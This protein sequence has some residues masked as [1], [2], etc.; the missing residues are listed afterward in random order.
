MNTQILDPLVP[1]LKNNEAQVTSNKQ[2]T[3]TTTVQ[4][5]NVYIYINIMCVYVNVTYINRKLSISKGI[6]R[7]FDGHKSSSQSLGDICTSI[8]HI[9]DDGADLLI[10][11]LL[12]QNIVE[13]GVGVLLLGGGVEGGGG[14]P[15]LAVELGGGSCGCGWLCGWG[16][17]VG[18]GRAGWSEGGDARCGEEGE[19][20][21]HG[22]S[23]SRVRQQ[24]TVKCGLRREFQIKMYAIS[25]TNF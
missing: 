14:G 20:E 8:Q 3:T 24:M 5:W 10:L 12:V 21:F 7:P 15:V 22:A 17:L 2:Q 4:L 25:S 6:R 18:E 13:G 1:L 9:L 23:W 11:A 16:E 19:E